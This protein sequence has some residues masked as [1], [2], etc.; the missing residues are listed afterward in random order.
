MHLV[1]RYLS[2]FFFFF[3]TY[4]YWGHI[5]DSDLSL[6]VAIELLDQNFAYS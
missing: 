5:Y 6:P 1:P 2:F 3:V 4:L